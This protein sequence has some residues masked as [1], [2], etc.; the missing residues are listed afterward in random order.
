MKPAIKLWDDAK[1]EGAKEA[2]EIILRLLDKIEMEDSNTS[3]E[4]WKQYKHIR[5]QITDKIK[6][7]Y[8][9]SLY[10]TLSQSKE[11]ESKTDN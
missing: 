4:Q 6:S 5:N 3:M 9:Q 11:K 2:C 7:Q 1:K 8:A 10:K